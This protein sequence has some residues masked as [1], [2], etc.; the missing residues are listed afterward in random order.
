[1]TLPGSAGQ[2]GAVYTPNGQGGNAGL[3]L[4]SYT[5]TAGSCS[6]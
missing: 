4:L 3:V 6:L 1:L 2:G 5:I